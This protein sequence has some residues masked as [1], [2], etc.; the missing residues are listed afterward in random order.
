MARSLSITRHYGPG[1][2]GALC[3][4]AVADTLMALVEPFGYGNNDIRNHVKIVN[5]PARASVGSP[6]DD[7][8][9]A[10]T[11]AEERART[12]AINLFA[13]KMC[14][15]KQAARTHANTWTQTADDARHDVHDHLNH[16][17]ACVCACRCVCVRVC[18][19]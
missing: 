18:V 13:Y 16:I 10:N 15:K 3:A 14:R 17:C 9:A 8:S 5:S 1:V 19:V 4:V 7:A 2:D 6:V 11:H 12:L